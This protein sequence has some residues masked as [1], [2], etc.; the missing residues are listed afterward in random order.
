[1]GASNSLRGTLELGGLGATIV[2]N[3][4]HSFNISAHGGP[5]VAPPRVAERSLDLIQRGVKG[6]IC[7][8][9]TTD[10]VTIKRRAGRHRSVA[11]YRADT[12]TSAS[13]VD[14]NIYNWIS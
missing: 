13:G 6:R 3:H 2:L 4:L 14:C 8:G 5:S 7:R 12:H 11:V 10:T 1:M 9:I